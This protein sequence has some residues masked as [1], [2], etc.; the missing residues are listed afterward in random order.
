[1]MHTINHMKK[2]VFNVYCIYAFLIGLK[3]PVPA[4]YMEDFQFNQ[5]KALGHR[6][7]LY[8]ME[9]PFLKGLLPQSDD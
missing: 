6:S 8:Y 7:G 1:M 4:G 2:F 9:L 5:N 3:P